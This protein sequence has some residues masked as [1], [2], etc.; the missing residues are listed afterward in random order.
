VSPSAWVQAP[1]TLCAMAEYKEVRV[2]RLF[3]K[4]PNTDKLRK[5][6]AGRH[7]HLL[8]SGWRELE[9][10]LEFDHVRI[11]YERTGHTP[12]KSRLPKGEAE[13]PR[14]DRRPRGQFGGGGRGFGGRGG[15]R[16]GPRGGGGG[17]GGRGGP[18]AGRGA[19]GRGPQTPA[20]PQ[21]AAGPQPGVAPAPAGPQPGSAPPS[22]APP[23]ETQK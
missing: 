23:P 18:S 5:T 7:R 21:T 3:L 17:P 11:R 10:K 14:M 4:V 16:G 2:E 6:A 19:G 13:V 22:S 1:V 12:L 8:A 15:G 20:G 9:R